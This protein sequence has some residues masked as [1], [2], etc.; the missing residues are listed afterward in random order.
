MDFDGISNYNL[1]IG[2]DDLEVGEK[3]VILVKF[4]VENCGINVGLF[5]NNVYVDVVFFMGEEV[6][7]VFMLGFDL[8]LNGDGDLDENGLIIIVFE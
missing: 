3:G 7:D 5:F 1:L 8:D 6:S 2:F 4:L